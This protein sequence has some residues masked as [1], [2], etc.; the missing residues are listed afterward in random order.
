MKQV[1]LLPP[2]SYQGGKIRL[3]TGIATLIGD[4]DYFYELCCGSAAVS[5]EMINQGLSPSHI[6]LLDKSEMGYFWK[7]I[8]N[9][10]FDLS[11]LKQFCDA[12]PSPEYIQAYMQKLSEQPIV[13]DTR[14][15]VYL[16]LQAG[17]F[18]GKQIWTKDGK[19]QNTTFRKYWLPN[20]VANRT[21]PVMPMSPMPQSLYERMEQIV[22]QCRGIH[23]YQQDIMEYIQ[24]TE[25][26]TNAVVYID[27]PYED[28]TK[29]GFGFDVNQMISILQ[30]KRVA[31]WVSYNRALEGATESICL[32]AGRKKGGI[33]GNR[34][35]KPN[36]EWLCKFY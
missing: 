12:V 25:F 2:C 28:T 30:S 16:L 35:T 31:F 21:S 11:V 26:E 22:R 27:P 36:E 17:A 4:C 29:Y 7:S 13:D 9:G 15:Y 6:T 19:W 5:L 8:A 14:V 18:G 3:A 33:S 34:K 1:R 20:G 10:T 23:A 24:T 32:S